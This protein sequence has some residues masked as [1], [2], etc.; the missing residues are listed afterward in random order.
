M[1]AQQKIEAPPNVYERLNDAREQFHASEI[2]KSGKFPKGRGGYFELGDFIVPAL[3]IFRKCGL[4][5]VVSFVGDEA[6]LD[7]VNTA[8]PEEV[9]RFCSPMGSAN[10]SGCHE[11]QNIGAVQ[12]YQ[13]RY[14]WMMALEIVEHDAIDSTLGEPPAE[15]QPKDAE[16]KPAYS[17]LKTAARAFVHEME[18]VGD[19]DEWCAFRDLPA[20]QKLIADV[21]EKLPQWWDGGPDMQP[22]FVPL[23]RRIELLEAGFANEIADI[24]RA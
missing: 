8:N 9:I 2:K 16:K 4:A 13:R 10:L 21:Q 7:V 15:V 18:G 5:G 3:Q 20:S 11:V 17:A 1:T 12:T 19:W 6:R 22:E 23:R 14:L 24:A